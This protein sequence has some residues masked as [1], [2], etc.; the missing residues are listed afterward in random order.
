M[1][2]EK[3]IH[4]CVY[5]SYIAPYIYVCPTPQVGV[6]DYDGTMDKG[7]LEPAGLALGKELV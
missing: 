3:N 6:V 4:V 7:V 1:R 2:K 5:I